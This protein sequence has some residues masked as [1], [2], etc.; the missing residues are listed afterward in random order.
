MRDLVFVKFNSKLRQNKDNKDRDPLEK[1]VLDAIE[2]EENE[3]ITGIK[4]TEVD[5]EQ[6]REIGSS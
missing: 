6:E 4:P 3:W 2:D 1:P 5:P